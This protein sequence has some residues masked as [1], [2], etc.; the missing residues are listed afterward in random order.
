MAYGVQS[1]MTRHIRDIDTAVC[2]VLWNLVVET[3]VD[4]DGELALNHRL[5]LPHWASACGYVAL[6]QSSVVT[7]SESATKSADFSR[8]RPSPNPRFFCGRKWRFWVVCSRVS[9]YLSGGPVQTTLR[10]CVWPPV[11]ACGRLNGRASAAPPPGVA[12][13]VRAAALRVAMGGM[14][15]WC[16]P[17]SVCGGLHFGQWTRH[18]TS[19]CVHA[20]ASFD[21]GRVPWQIQTM[22]CIRL[23]AVLD[24]GCRR[25]E[26]IVEWSGCRSDS[27]V[28][29]GTAASYHGRLVDVSRP[30]GTR[31]TV[32][33]D[34]GL[35]IVVGARRVGLWLRLSLIH[36][37]RCRRSYAC[38]SR[39]S[40]YH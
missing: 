27:A 9:I 33:D 28:L 39:W 34:Y 8:V 25:R 10:N 30:C 21:A 40:P 4:C 36:I 14:W 2:Q 6:W 17:V 35:C 24:A 11:Q 15:F 20:G 18:W 3:P 26:D 29:K 1:L 7:D 22:S 19:V 37:W 13:A 38:R 12:A 31:V 23:E 32:Q 5:D 16:F